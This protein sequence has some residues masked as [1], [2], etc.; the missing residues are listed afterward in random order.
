MFEGAPIISQFY[1]ANLA[2]KMPK[3][4]TKMPKMAASCPIF[5]L[6]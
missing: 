4:A 2:L 3:L 5:A 1:E 6:F